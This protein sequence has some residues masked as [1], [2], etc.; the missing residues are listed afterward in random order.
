MLLWPQFRS[1]LYWDA[2]DILSFLVVS[3]SVWY[4]GLL[5]DLAALRD[6][7]VDRLHG[8]DREGSGGRFGRRIAQFY[9]VAALGWRG[10]AP[11]WHRRGQALRIVGLLGIVVVVS[12]QTGAAVMFA[13]TPDRAGTTRC[14]RWSSWWSPRSPASP[15]ARWCWWWCARRSRSAA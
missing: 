8:D 4:L 13:G 12:L 14:S 9:G 6:R 7:A 11:H 2:I 10:S 1:P 5:P 3:L 15:P